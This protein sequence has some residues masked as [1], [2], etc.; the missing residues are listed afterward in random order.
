ME[1]K[2]FYIILNKSKCIGCGSCVVICNKYFDIDNEGLSTLIK[3]DEV[4]KEKGI[5]KKGS[6]KKPLKEDFLC[7]KEAEEACPVN[8]IE[9]IEIKN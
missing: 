5:E 4:D 6:K 7:A 2:N 8:C 9:V 3:K 1:D